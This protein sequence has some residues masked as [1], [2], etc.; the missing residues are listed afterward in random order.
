MANL[1]IVGEE[2]ELVVQLSGP[3][4]CN[5][6]DASARRCRRR[7]S[8][9]LQQCP[10]TWSLEGGHVWN[11]NQGAEKDGFVPGPHSFHH[12]I[13]N[14]YIQ[15][16]GQAPRRHLQKLRHSAS[17]WK[18]KHTSVMRVRSESR[19][20]PYLVR[21]LLDL[22]PL[23]VYESALLLDKLPQLFVPTSRRRANHW[24]GHNELLLYIA[25]KLTTQAALVRPQVQLWSH[26]CRAC[27]CTFPSQKSA[28][29]HKRTAFR[30]AE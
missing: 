2:G 29:L 17:K 26:F 4:G 10:L 14:D 21:I 19:R 23:P 20:A 7:S 24:I 6:R 15:G 18:I 25:H 5:A 27:D 22:G 13:S 3:G 30:N 16:T 28:N 8:L 12:L 11:H 1:N 9:G